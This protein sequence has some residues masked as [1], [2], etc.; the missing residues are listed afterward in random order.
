MQK[1]VLISAVSVTKK[2]YGISRLLGGKKTEVTLKSF[3]QVGI[4][5]VDAERNEYGPGMC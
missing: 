4:A 2:F 1:S 5:T 3:C